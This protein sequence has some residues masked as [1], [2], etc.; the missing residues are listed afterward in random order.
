MHNLA[1]G[2]REGC[3]P[4]WPLCAFWEGANSFPA[5]DFQLR[6]GGG[7][8]LPSSPRRTPSPRQPGISAA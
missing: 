1:R 2:G 6:K 7:A 5:S 3:P 4:P 8:S